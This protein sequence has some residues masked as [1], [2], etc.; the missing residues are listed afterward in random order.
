MRHWKMSLPVAAFCCWSVPVLAD[1]SGT[2]AVTGS[3]PGGGGTYRGEVAVQSTGQ[4]FDVTW[5]ILRDTFTGTGIAHGDTLSVVYESATSIPGVIQ[6][7]RTEDG[8]EGVWTY[9]GEDTNGTETWLATAPTASPEINDTAHA[10]GSLAHL[11]GKF[12][13]I[14]GYEAQ[15]IAAV[16]EVVE[17]SLTPTNPNSIFMPSTDLNAFV[18]A[19]VTLQSHEAEAG[20]TVLERYRYRL[21]YG[22]NEIPQP[23]KASLLPVSFIQI[24][25]FNIGPG[26]REDLIGEH[27]ED[28]VAPPAEFGEM[29]HVSWRLVMVPV[30]GQRASIVTASRKEI[31]D[32]NAQSETCLGAPCLDTGFTLGNA[33]P[34]GD[35]PVPE[36]DL[37]VAY[38]TERNGLITP[39]AAIDMLSANFSYEAR[40]GVPTS[41]PFAEAV[42]EMNL[43]QD[44]SLQAAFREGKLMDDSVS[45]IWRSIYALPSGPGFAAQFSAAQAFEC[46]RGPEFAEP[47]RYCP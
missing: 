43:A 2:Y 7:N 35:M 34:W 33:V 15:D 1:P 6:M 39:A 25:R 27:G 11:A 3:N 40:E 24:D 20:D 9:I 47:G 36:R 44:A 42:I 14:D 5:T 46:Q 16:D 45:A 37:D 13:S 26:T 4:N 10:P 31:S 38:Q 8:W 18:K 41:E 28:I 22:Q 32:A 12:T 23:P 17:A 30:Q 29:P 19:V 21:R